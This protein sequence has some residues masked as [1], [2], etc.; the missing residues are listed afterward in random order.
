VCAAYGVLAT[1][2]AHQQL[3]LS[4][5]SLQG[6]PAGDDK[7]CTL[8]SGLVRSQL[9][10]VRTVLLLPG[11]VGGII[12]LLV[13]YAITLWSSLLLTECHE[14]GGMKHP[15]YRSAVLHILGEWQARH[16]ATAVSW[17]CHGC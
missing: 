13:F 7:A 10:H 9:C 11:W 16:G 3:Q 6:L 5:S 8:L 15:T 4:D 1:S 14:T 12:T 17:D 2:C